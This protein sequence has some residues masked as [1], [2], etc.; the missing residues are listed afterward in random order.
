MLIVK[1]H[2]CDY[3]SERI[4]ESEYLKYLRLANG[5]EFILHHTADLD[6]YNEM[7]DSLTHCDCC[8][9]VNPH[10]ETSTVLSCGSWSATEYTY[11]E[12]CYDDYTS[13]CDH[14]EGRFHNDYVEYYAGSL[15]CDNCRDEYLFSCENCNEYSHSDQA[16]Y[17]EDEGCYYCE[18]CYHDRGRTSDNGDGSLLAYSYKPSPI[19]YGRHTIEPAYGIEI[20]IEPDRGVYGTS[21]LVS[22]IYHTDSEGVYCKDDCTIRGA[23]VVFHP[24]TLKSYCKN[25]TLILLDKLSSEG[26]IGNLQGRCG[27]HLH[28]GKQ[29]FRPMALYNLMNMFSRNRSVMQFLSGRNPDVYTVSIPGDCPTVLDSYGDRKSFAYRAMKKYYNSRCAINLANHD[30][31]EFR[32]FDGTA[33]KHEVLRA[34][35][36]VQSLQELSSSGLG[37][38]AFK[39]PDIVGRWFD[40]VLQDRRYR[41]FAKLIKCTPQLIQEVS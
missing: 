12:S 3:C 1:D 18:E 5:E 8:G 17:D 26:V 22:D 36:I 27:L 4:D 32:M 6:C 11:C 40:G 14:C 29:W 35:E 2:V 16:C 7:K 10:E 33:R 30:T 21:E 37:I 13:G 41:N 23:E 20:E 38:G 28:I 15:Y 25:S 34:I 19:F 39:T 24:R 31:V 9:K